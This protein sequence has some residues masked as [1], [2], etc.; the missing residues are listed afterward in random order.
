M[1]E[2]SVPGTYFDVLKAYVAS[3]DETLLLMAA[4]LG[5]ELVRADIPPE[6][7][8]EI[9]EDA[10]YRLALEYPDITLAK[11]VR[12]ISAPFME[13]SMAYGLAFREQLE[14][15]KRAEEAREREHQRLE[16]LV[17]TSSVGILVVDAVSG[18]VVLVNQEMERIFGFSLSLDNHLERFD[19][20]IIF[21]RPDGRHHVPEDLPLQRA[22]REGLTVRAEEV[23]LEFP[24]GRTIST[25]VNA[26]PLYTGDGQ[27]SGAVAVVQDITKLEE[28]EKQRSE[29][30]GVVTHEL[31]T[32]LATIKGAAATAL[33]SQTPLDAIELREFFQII[34]QQ[35]DHLTG[36]VN[37]LLE[38]TR[39]EAGELPVSPKPL[40]LQV[41]LEEA[42]ATL[43]RSGFSH[44]VQIRVPGDLP[45]ARADGRRI[46]QV[47]T[48]LLNNAARFSPLTAPITIETESDPTYI[49]VHVRDLGR[50][51]PSEALPQLFRKFS[52]LHDEGERGLLGTGLGLAI[53]KGIIEA[54]GGR[55]WAQSPGE[56]KGATFSFTLPVATAP[57][58]PSL[59]G[60]AQEAGHLGRVSR[61]G[62][63]T[64]ILALDDDLHTLRYLRR[65]LDEAGYEAIVTSD[66][67]E[68]IKLVELEE[69]DLVLLDLM[70]PR[71][72]GFD[73]IQ[74][75]REFSGVPV[76]FLT[77]RETDEDRVR[78]LRLGADDYIVKP[79]SSSELLARI[80]TVLRRSSFAG[81]VEGEAPV[82]LGDLTI[83]FAG[84][85]VTIGGRAVSLTPTEYK[86]LCQLGINAG[87][88]LTHDQILQQVWGPEYSGE[89][90]LVRS[91]VRNLRRKL[92]EDARHPRYILSEPGVGYRMP[93]P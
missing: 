38:L 25:L 93:R 86:L 24:D 26:R 68:A 65:L 30:L 54:H 74:R 66:P 51:I 35:V 61:P 36:L 69:P 83:D 3:P 7:M 53:C 34:D 63:G 73:L 48:N 32:P 91:M 15:R 31:R 2:Q 22:L 62:K 84:R 71:T 60:A 14:S 56:D 43:D 10:L 55:I 12:L 21:R 92:D 5:R 11:A 75:I 28:A 23:H 88:V 49:T 33:D 39:I 80:E 45:Q 70:L 6:E 59:P 4:D 9:H 76:I 89:P 18:E 27:I 85:Q 79:F 46:V 58:V 16:A 81:Q 42:L 87:R 67:S 41:V 29:F 50:G 17:A 8:T 78:G 1:A 72:S 44:E 20:Q 13:M 47:L 19:Q 77:A 57:P 82:T 64:H 90:E 40:D 52:R 37:N